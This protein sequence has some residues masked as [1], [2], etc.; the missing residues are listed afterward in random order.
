MERKAVM[1][2]NESMG[3]MKWKEIKRLE[4]MKRQIEMKQ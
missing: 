2:R 3:R 4:A 1:G